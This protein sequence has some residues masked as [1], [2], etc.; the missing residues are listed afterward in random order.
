MIDTSRR[1]N[2]PCPVIAP[3]NRSTERTHRSITR[4]QTP[5]SASSAPG[6]VATAAAVSARNATSEPTCTERRNATASEIE[7]TR[8][9]T[10]RAEAEWIQKGSGAPH[11]V[12]GERGGG[13]GERG[14]GGGE[15]DAAEE[16]EEGRG[17]RGGEGLVAERE[18]RGAPRPRAAAGGRGHRPPPVRSRAGGRLGCGRAGA[19]SPRGEGGGRVGLS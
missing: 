11:L 13:R 9:E 7:P 17:L 5:R 3:Y 8:D 1:H 14:R 16:L 10:R 4:W 19:G 12:R 18:Q 2:Q 6:Q 15:E